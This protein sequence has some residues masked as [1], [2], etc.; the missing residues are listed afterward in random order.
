MARKPLPTGSLLVTGLS[1]YAKIL[2]DPVDNYLKDNKEWTFDLQ[3]N[4]ET[5]RELKAQGLGKIIKTKDGYL[6]D[7][8]FLRFKQKYNLGNGRTAKP[9]KVVDRNGKEWD[10]EALIGNGSVLRVRF[11]VKDYGTTVGVYPQAVQVVKHVAYNG[12]A[13]FPEIEDDEFGDA[14]TPSSKSK[15]TDDFDD[16]IPF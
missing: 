1:S 9:I 2:G 14:E 8:P 15:A 3:I 16:D 5:V 12:G 11:S 6:D 13:D 4:Q 10:Q 7:E